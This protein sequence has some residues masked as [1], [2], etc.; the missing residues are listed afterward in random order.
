MKTPKVTVLMSVYNGETFLKEAIESILTQTYS[1]FEFVIYDDC[2]TDK[3]VDIIKSFADSRIILRQNTRNKG[4]TSNLAD[5]INRCENKYIV[6]MDCDDIAFPNRIER[7]VEWMEQHKEISILGSS[8]HY[9]SKEI[10]DNGILKQPVEDA[11]IKAMLFIDFSLMHP[12]IIIRTNDLKIRNINYNTDFKYSQDH[13]LYFECIKHNLKFGNIE[14]PLLYMRTH[15]KSISKEKH[16]IQQEYSKRARR[17]FLEDIGI[18]NKFTE[19]EIIIYNNFASNQFFESS[20]EIKL[21]ERFISKFSSSPVILNY[22]NINHL[23]DCICN[24]LLSEAYQNICY[25]SKK[26]TALRAFRSPLCLNSPRNS[27]STSLRFYIKA[28]L[29]FKTSL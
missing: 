29:Q 24:K 11:I 25:K 16:N 13:A 28:L 22:F 27:F 23:R 9:F 14:Q 18:L 1:N 2:S 17:K 7:Q 12:S 26:F 19:Q 15:Q 21:F 10:G 6:R 8:V 5:G 3:S 4:L 20:E